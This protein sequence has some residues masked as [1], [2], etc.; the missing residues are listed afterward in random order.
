MPSLVLTA[1]VTLVALDA[2]AQSTGDIHGVVVEQAGGPLVGAAIT[3]DNR[4][5]GA[6]RTAISDI[7]G[8][9]A[10]PGLPVGTYRITAT[11]AG[12]AEVRDDGIDVH[13]CRAVTSRL[14]MRKAP[15]AETITVT[16]PS[17]GIT[18]GQP[19]V[20]VVISRGEI[21]NE[22]LPTRD[23]F[24]L[25][26]LVP[27][28][29][30][31]RRAGGWSAFALP[32]TFNAAVVDGTDD[33]NSFFG[34]SFGR[35]TRDRGAYQ[36]GQ[37]TVAEI[38]V[39]VGAPRAEFGDGATAFVNAVTRS[40]SDR[41]EGELFGQ[42]RDGGLP[43]TG[44]TP[45]QRS[46]GLDAPPLHAHQFGGTVGGPI[47]KGIFF[48]AAYDGLRS[49]DANDV[50]PRFDLS[51]VSLPV[52][53][54]WS[55]S[56]D[57]DVAFLRTD[58]RIGRDERLTVRYNRQDLRG[59]GLEQTG[60]LVTARGSGQSRVQTHS[61]SGT[62]GSAFGRKWMNEFR[63]LYGRD[64][65]RGTATSDPHVD[66]RENGALVLSAGGDATNPHDT[67]LDR[68][69]VA[70]ALMLTAGAHTLKAG[71]DAEISDVRDQSGA[72]VAGA[73]VFQSVAGAIGG[74]PGA[75]GETYSQAFLPGGATTSLVRPDSRRYAAFVQ[76][77]WPI[78]STVTVDAGV[79]Y[80]LQTWHDHS[81]SLNE[82]MFAGTS[83][84]TQLPA[85]DTNNWAPRVGIAWTPSRR[86]V[87]R[88]AY[89]IGYT[90]T[91]SSLAAAVQRYGSGQVLLTTSDSS[92]AALPLAFA[93]ARDFELPWVQ[94]VTAGLEWEWM[95]QTSVS[96]NYIHAGGRDLPQLTERNAGTPLSATVVDSATGT[97]FPYVQYS[98]GLF[99]DFSR[100]VAIESTG[101]STYDAIGLALVRDLHQGIHYRLAYTVSKGTDNGVASDVI[102]LTTDDRLAAPSDAPQHLTAAPSDTDRRHRF[103][104]DFVYFT[105]A[106]AARH[107]GTMKT[108]LDKWRLAATYS[109]DSGL[110]YT[111]YVAS[112]LNGD[113]NALNDIAPGTTRNQFRRVQE[114]LLNARLARA[115]RFGAVDLTVSL[116]VFNAV[117]ATHNRDVD[118]VLY[119][120][121]GG[122]LFVN[123]QFGQTYTAG[124][125]RVVQLG[126]RVGF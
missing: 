64:R 85:A 92:G 111:A 29:P 71:V 103:V 20:G 21:D 86:Y 88:L 9:F 115:I 119:A 101:T 125:P 52:P 110:P 16:P 113:G 8:A 82:P 72:Y 49:R 38:T 55:Q 61:L 89:G 54:A 87:A 108:L 24:D 84:T 121:S 17:L 94:H 67:T 18:P 78:G 80:D 13:V 51:S 37:R 68:W 43:G 47:A 4:H 57:Q 120:T 93:F 53:D 3:A 70:N 90:Q 12:F 76:D 6:R 27:L 62:F 95:P 1:A 75:P 73:Y 22:P 105:D 83:L 44:T 7:N 19:T 60:D 99:S 81:P 117:N 35:H 58:V 112:D 63:A 69:Q 77:T 26:A 123:P 32:G 66:V 122:V 116:D 15:E 50:V 42:Y 40:G 74:V 23:P 106:F 39:D 124:E 98:P 31:D 34:T 45:V 91:P 36:F 114:G 104:A 10:I 30:A 96:L 118:D 100:V 79:R 25:V 59:T 97:A 14:V 48:F 28:L 41:F 126:L 107:R 11:L 65:D 109:L 5:T 56:R 33:F 2:Q 102:P 46:R